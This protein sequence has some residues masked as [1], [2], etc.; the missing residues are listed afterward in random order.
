MTT[1]MKILSVLM[2]S[3]VALL[4]NVSVCNGKDFQL[5]DK[6]KAQIIKSILLDSDFLNRGLRIGERKEVAIRTFTAATRV[7][8]PYGTP[9]PFY[10]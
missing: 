8:L 3:L 2:I 4:A 7:R 5:S 1:G 6:D 9:F 10:T